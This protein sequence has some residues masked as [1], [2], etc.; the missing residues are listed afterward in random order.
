[1]PTRPKTLPTEQTSALPAAAQ[2][3]SLLLLEA[4]GQGAV[5]LSTAGTITA[6]NHA[7]E[8]ILGLPVTDLLGRELTG[9]TW[10]WLAENGS[11]L[12]PTRHPASIALSSAQ[13]VLHFTIGLRLPQA[14]RPN[15]YQVS[16]V[17]KFTP[18]HAELEQVCVVFDD[19]TAQKRSERQLEERRKELQAFYTF[20]EIAEL[21][22]LTLDEQ[23]QRII[24]ALPASWQHPQITCGR[25]E[26]LGKSFTSRNYKT[27]VYQQVAD[28]KV[29]GVT[30]GSLQIGYLAECPMEDEGPF[31]LEERL[32]LDA[33]AKRI[34]RLTERRRI[35][36]TLNQEINIGLAVQAAGM[37][38]W[39]QDFQTRQ[40][41]MDSTARRHM[42]L[43][44]GAIFSNDFSSR[45]HPD[46]IDTLQYIFRSALSQKKT[47]PVKCEFRVVDPDGSTRWLA[48]DYLIEYRKTEAD[49]VPVQAVGTM[50][51]ITRRKQAEESL[52][53]KTRALYVLS[54]CD[55][56]LVKQTD[57]ITLL[58]EICRICVEDGGYLLA[59]IGYLEHDV[60]KSIRPVAQFGYDQDYLDTAII[61]WADD[62]H[63]R[64]PAGTAVRTN[65]PCIAQNIQQDPNFAP[66]HAAAA[67]RGY[68][69]SIALPLQ[70]NGEV[71][72]VFSVYSG[73]SFAFKPDEIG[74]LAELANDVSYAISALRTRAKQ[75]RL[76]EDLRI[77]E[78]RYKL[79]QQAAGIGIWEWDLLLDGMFWSD[80]VFRMFAKDPLKYTPTFSGMMDAL[81]PED[82]PEVTRIF[83]ESIAQGSPFEFE[84]RLYGEMRQVKWIHVKGDV[85]RNASGITGLVSGAV[86]DITQRK[87]VEIALHQVEETQHALID[88]IT[89]SVLLV[90]PDGGGM[91]ANLTTLQQLGI[92]QEQFK[93]RNYFDLLP[94]EAVKLQKAR[95]ERV[96]LDHQPV[97][98][99]DSRAGR[100]YLNSIN[101]VIG[102]DG[103]LSA[104]AIFSFDITGRVQAE[105][106][107]LA[108]ERRTKT[109]VNAIPDL[110]FRITQ[111]GTFLDYNAKSSDDLYIPPEVFVGKKMSEVLPPE[112]AEKSL[113]A[114]QQA[115]ERNSL[116]VFEYT[117]PFKG[118]SLI[119][120]SRVVANLEQAEAVVIVR[121][122]TEQRAMEVEIRQSEERYRQLS[123]ELEQRLEE[124][125]QMQNLHAAEKELLSTTLMSIF[126]GVIVTD[127]DGIINLFNRS[128]ELITGFS[129][130][131]ALDHPLNAVFQLHDSNT[132]ERIPDLINALMKMDLAQ[133]TGSNYPAPT[134]VNRSGDRLL[135][136][137]SLSALKSISGETF[138]YVI[139]FQDATVKYLSESQTI[140]SQK[141][142][143]IGQLAAGIAHE[144]NTPIQY[145][146][147]NLKFLS[148]A[149]LRYAEMLEVYRQSFETHLQ[150]PYSQEDIAVLEET[151]RQKR[152]S[153]YASEIPAAIVEALDGTERVRKIV[154]AMREFSHPSEKE[155]KPA[156]LN[157]GIETTIAI[158]RNEWKYYADLETDLD[159][160]LPFVY[161]QI[162]EI[163]QVILNMIVN[164]AQ[165]IQEK[166]TANPGTKEIISIK[167]R[168]EKDHVLIVIQDTGPGIPE[169]I[170][171]RIFN[172]FFTT[173]GIGKGTGQ[174][175]SLAHNIIVK[176]HQG[177]IFVDSE[178]GKGTTF[179][180]E[181]PLGTEESERTW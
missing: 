25:L 75:S 41:F 101:P 34:G 51:D 70:V 90:A 152:I 47:V 155:K 33:L 52:F 113:Y 134:L 131:E 176:K 117:L 141:M 74:L 46:D 127:P 68:A 180:I 174:G 71:I 123:K 3:D 111:D 67:K 126:E 56:S 84:V 18:D 92:T 11:V 181:L 62:E 32:L 146:G 97:Q 106:E 179:T 93:N 156:D 10:Q 16:A 177:K 164:A 6:A 89:E 82:R 29:S 147:D 169:N 37:G 162:D 120:E 122:V 58:Q 59:W 38:K 39:Q 19:I 144:I 85:V 94:A 63:G 98:F 20:S 136:S 115:F 99:E 9:P 138:G 53:Y 104:L 73:D 76:E 110:L 22:E 50:L 7:I 178:V 125:T 167:T 54:T 26:I 91:L 24:D 102:P 77:S 150:I 2:T 154:L 43:G 86:R 165:A 4:L 107:L 170:R 87:K 151:R 175:L 153:H 132:Q 55:Q 124:I 64:G 103:A 21:D 5:F 96:I 69:A 40:F 83:N 157:R 108:S 61:S 137:G 45:V 78:G 57:E 88:A 13:A 12:K 48:L 23:Y 100:H 81:V 143:A 139:V 142:E 8:P 173:K 118:Q 159:P 166:I 116:Q 129:A 114:I 60:Q 119:Y 149:F 161:C 31:L 66:W 49:Q 112:I 1:M 36:E 27:P 130:S 135:V 28:L 17:P 128:A 72:G 44:P 140:L 171:A 133:K 121:N 145:I 80:E 42:G 79:A 35:H 172:P 109:M 160:N 15:W 14:A 158:S 30:A 65:S 105:E 168:Q 163:N 148:K 95:F